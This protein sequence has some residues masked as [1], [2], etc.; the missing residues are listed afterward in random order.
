MLSTQ[1]SNRPAAH[2]ST[3]T[4]AR[5]A[6]DQ[7]GAG[8]HTKANEVATV[9]ADGNQTAPHGVTD[10]IAGATMN[11]DRAAGHP[12]CT[13]SISA[14]DEMPSAAADID[15][16][17]AH[18]RADPVTHI[19]ADVDLTAAHLAADM[20]PRTPV[21]AD[22]PRR[23]LRADPVNARHI[24]AED[25]RAISR[26]ATYRKEFRER[27]LGIAM[28]DREFLDLGTR[29][30]ARDVGR[31]PFDLQRD[32]RGGFE[33]ELECH[34]GCHASERSQTRVY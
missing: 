25:Q 2:V 27:Y 24:A 33:R 1:E 9:A 8:Q 14:T 15:Q 11:E 17:A 4:N 19:V 10:F 22:R 23:H 26:F 5:R 32:M 28:E 3:M 7:D 29:Q 18:F 20:P 34:R 31:E 16:P 30:P 13:A 12:L 6:S 21:N